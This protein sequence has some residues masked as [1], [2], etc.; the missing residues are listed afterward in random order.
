M[1]VPIRRQPAG[2]NPISPTPRSQPA[3]RTRVTLPIRTI[4][5][6]FRFT[7]G[8]LKLEHQGPIIACDFYIDGAEKGNEITGGYEIDGITNIDHHAP[9]SRMMRHVSSTNLAIEHMQ[10]EGPA[11]HNSLVIISHTDC[12]SVL[13]S[14]IMSG[15]LTPDAR[16]GEAAIAADHTG[17]PDGIADVL[18][19]LEERRDLYFSLRNLRKLLEGEPLDRIAQPFYAK[20][21]RKREAAAEAIAASKIRVESSLAFGVLEEK[22]D[23]EFFPAKL[24]NAAVIL[25]MTPRSDPGRWDAKMRLCLN[26]PTGAGLQNLD[27]ARFDPAFA[28]RWNAGSNSRNGGTGIEPEVYARHVAEAMR[29]AWGI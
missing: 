20:R 6:H 25:I 11:P 5:H 22:L 27:T 7:P 29:D 13:S 21:L 1:S 10:R 2:R 3:T 8:L 24:P 23:G 26:A 16:F 14:A 15:D 4:R 18:Q 17:A 19:S 28:G 9:T 12:D